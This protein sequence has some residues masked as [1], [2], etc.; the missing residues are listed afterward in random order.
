MDKNQQI[1]SAPVKEFYDLLK[2]SPIE[3][4]FSEDCTAKSISTTIE[5]EVSELSL[6]VTNNKDGDASR[7]LLR[8]DS[9]HSNDVIM[10]LKSFT[11]TKRKHHLIW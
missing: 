9:D 1:K 11:K 3:F 6:T 7:F 10:T 2:I 8:D 4:V 5:G